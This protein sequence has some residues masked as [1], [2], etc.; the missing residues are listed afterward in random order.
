MESFDVESSPLVKSIQSSSNRSQIVEQL[1]DY[2]IYEKSLGP[3]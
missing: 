1:Y 2:D 3:E